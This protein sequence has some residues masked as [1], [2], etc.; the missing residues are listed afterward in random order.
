M[1]EGWLA[2]PLEDPADKIAD[3]IWKHQRANRGAFLPRDL[4]NFDAAFGSLTAS[5]VEGEL[6][7]YTKSGGAGKRGL[8]RLAA[9][10]SIKCNAF[11]DGER[12]SGESSARRL[13]RVQEN[14]KSAV[15][16]PG[17]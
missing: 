7:K 13:A 17:G 1:I 5:F 12:G 8:Y 2:K 3:E 9:A 14:F 6:A 16:K 10:L 15:R 11:G 4:A